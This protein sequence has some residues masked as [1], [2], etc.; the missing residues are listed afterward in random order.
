MMHQRPPCED[1]TFEFE[2]FQD[3]INA[4]PFGVVYDAELNFESLVRRIT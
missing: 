4:Y 1:L 3:Y 2:R